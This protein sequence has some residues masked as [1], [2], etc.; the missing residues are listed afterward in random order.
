LEDFSFEGS[1]VMLAPASGFYSDP[2]LGLHQVRIAYVL[3]KQSLQKAMDCLAAALQQ[4]PG[5]TIPT[6]SQQITA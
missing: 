1:T 3:N 2:K 4:Y 5:R 6:T